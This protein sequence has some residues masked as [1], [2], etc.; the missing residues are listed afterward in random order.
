MA[1]DRGHESGANNGAY[2]FTGG[3]P[4][5]QHK[6]DVFTLEQIGCATQAPVTHSQK[7]K[8]FQAHIS[9]PLV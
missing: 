2:P 1:S 5:V 7:Q 6:Q 4:Q 9:T 3:G 8:S